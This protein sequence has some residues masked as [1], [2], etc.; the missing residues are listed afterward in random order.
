[1]LLIA[2]IVLL[3][4]ILIVIGV[5]I[6]FQSHLQGMDDQLRLDA[7][8]CEAVKKKLHEV[9]RMLASDQLRFA[10][11]EADKLL[12]FVVKE[13]LYEG[14][15]IEDHLES[16]R[17]YETRFEGIPEASSFAQRLQEQ[18][19]TPIDAQTAGRTVETYHRALKRLGVLN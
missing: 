17:E 10:V 19:S 16:V 8:D 13:M 3:A 4:M 5:A 1:M 9:D 11:I 12:H 18:P 14:Q 7:V 2:A 15:P 6:G